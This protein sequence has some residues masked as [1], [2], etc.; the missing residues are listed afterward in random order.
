MKKLILII[1]FSTIGL[2]AQN[3]NIAVASNV[4]YAIDE[5]K[6]EFKKINPDVD[7]RII[8]GSSGKLTAQIKNGAPYG[9]FL[10]ANMNYPTALYKDKIAISKPY[11]Y[12]KGS[13]AYFS[14]KKRDFSQITK[15]L[16]SNK[17]KK[18]AIGNPKTVPYGK[19]T[20]EAL[21]NAGIYEELKPKFIYA[22][23]ISQT[24]SYAMH[25]VDIAIVAYSALYSSK[26]NKYKKNI[27]YIELDARLYTPIKQGIVLLK[28][29]KTSKA[30][31]E[32]YDFILSKKA[33]EI[34]VKYGYLL[35]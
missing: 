22:E 5:L 13:L 24:L 29:S 30:Y 21:L 16:K 12:A 9:V 10:S 31:K 14:V 1:F 26:M 2:I 17:I 33:K 11:V 8:L 25:A 7:V 27:N 19:A 34:F 3:I 4:S 18:I 28:Y 23:S 6:T 32:F 15:L 20:K 35:L